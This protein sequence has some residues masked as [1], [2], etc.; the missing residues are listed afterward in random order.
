L[1]V[2]PYELI[3]DTEKNDGDFFR[4]I[5]SR[6]DS[7]K[8]SYNKHEKEMANE[9]NDAKFEEFIR[10]NN[11]KAFDNK[12]DEE[13]ETLRRPRENEDDSFTFGRILLKI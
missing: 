2:I 4:D 1:Y 8:M 5:D 6:L 3:D 10:K 12:Y 13:D 11:L 9:I 7:L